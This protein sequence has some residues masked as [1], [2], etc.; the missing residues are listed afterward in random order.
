MSTDYHLRIDLR[1]AL[2]HWHASEWKNC[3]R[4]DEGRMMT[5][6]EVQQEFFNLLESGVRFIPCGPCDNFDSEK[7]C[8]GHPHTDRTLQVFEASR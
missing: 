1:G 8:L 3:V 4:D 5:P 7:G 6:D 2:S